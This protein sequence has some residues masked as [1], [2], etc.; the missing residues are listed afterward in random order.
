M[1]TK[2]RAVFAADVANLDVT[3]LCRELDVSRDSYYRYRKRFEAEGPAGLVAR[4]RRPHHS[5]Q[6]MSPEVEDEIVRLRKQLRDDGLDCGA[7]SIAYRLERS[8]WPAPSARAVHRAL[9]RRGQVVPQPEK[10]PHTTSCRFE[11]P[12]PN[13]AWQIDATRWA[14]AQGKEVWIMD[15]LDDHSR[16]AVAARVVPGPSGQAAWEAFSTGAAA[17][18]LPAHVMS[19]N[20]SC[21][22][23]RFN[24]GGEVD[25]ERLL[26]AL[27]IRH[28]CSS[29]AH[30]QTCG[31]LERFHLTL[32]RWLSGRPLARTSAELQDQ[33]DEFL[34]IYNLDRPHRSLAGA[35]PAERWA[36]SP[37]D[38]PGASIAAPPVTGLQL[39]GAN[40]ALRWGERYSI[41]VGTAFAGRRL[42]VIGREH[43]V[44]IYSAKG[45]VRRLRL[46]PS[47]RYQRQS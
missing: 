45:L 23:G 27:G 15:V 22:T 38:G 40:G 13:A 41:G 1:E 7:Q 21:F 32:K 6:A 18:G 9:V 26:R 29:P 17:W 37:P 43:D 39:V 33:L 16:V 10:R 36:A 14:L 24:G 44:S 28:I 12:A 31:K 2:L 8:G 42:L 30:P 4:S 19:D 35:T 20:G 46:D 25:F 47:R 34:R 3:Q 11:W 5:P